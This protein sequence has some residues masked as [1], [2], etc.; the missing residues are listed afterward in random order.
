MKASIQS[1]STSSCKVLG[2]I[3]DVRFDERVSSILTGLE[4]LDNHIVIRASVP[5]FNLDFTFKQK[6][7]IAEGV[8]GELEKAM[9]AYR[10]EIVQTLI[11]DIKP[12]AQMKIAMNEINSEV[13]NPDFK[14]QWRASVK[15][16][17]ERMNE[18][19]KKKF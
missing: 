7:D 5:R 18:R 3:V 9:S 15:I 11:V 13:G 17:H 4:V 1:L 2:T 6:N 16:T 19:L 10:F 12:D 14:T 8:E